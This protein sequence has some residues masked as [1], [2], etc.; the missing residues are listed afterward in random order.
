M[1]HLIDSWRCHFGHVVCAS[2]S[3]ISTEWSTYFLQTFSQVSTS[4][5]YTI[6]VIQVQK[7]TFDY[8]IQTKPINSLKKKYTAIISILSRHLFG[9]SSFILNRFCTVTLDAKSNSKCVPVG[10]Y[11]TSAHHLKVAIGKPFTYSLLWKR[12][13]ISVNYL[14]CFSVVRLAF[15]IHLAIIIVITHFTCGTQLI[16]VYVYKSGYDVRCF[17]VF[18]NFPSYWYFAP[19][20]CCV[21]RRVYE[22]FLHSCSMI[23]RSAC[24]ASKNILMSAEGLKRMTQTSRSL[25]NRCLIALK[26]RLLCQ[27][28]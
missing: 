14:M 24:F 13:V 4:H 18:L 11:Y 28:K 3:I 8:R 17:S 10:I 23:A 15:A 1:L 21:S 12:S 2:G 25:L 20:M 5:D 16:N 9:C 19:S 27:I 26:S 22:P 6:Q 7:T